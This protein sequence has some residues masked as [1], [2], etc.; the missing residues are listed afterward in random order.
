[1]LW[2]YTENKGKYRRHNYVI[3]NVFYSEKHSTVLAY[4]Q[5]SP[6]RWT[7]REKE[8]T[9]CFAVASGSAAWPVACPSGFQTQRSPA[10][11]GCHKLRLWQPP[12]TETH[13]I[14]MNRRYGVPR[15][16]FLFLSFVTTQTHGLP[17]F[18]H[19]FWWLLD[20][21]LLY[22]KTRAQLRVWRSG[23]KRIRLCHLGKN[24]KT[25]LIFRHNQ[26]NKK[27]N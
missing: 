22:W 9:E 25:V 24:I 21:Q 2:R 17:L 23:W 14:L 16:F 8:V 11:W 1:M 15:F 12:T 5:W 20:A 10:G 19:G 18:Q 4:S 6:L 7:P 13:K 26:S 3:G 27:K